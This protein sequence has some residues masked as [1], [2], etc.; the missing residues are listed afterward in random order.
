MKSLQTD[1]AAAAEKLRTSQAENRELATK[2]AAANA[3]VAKL[4]VR[5]KSGFSLVWQLTKGGA[6]CGFCAA[7]SRICIALQATKSATEGL[8]AG[9]AAAA[10]DNG[11]LHAVLRANESLASRAAAAEATASRVPSLTAANAALA[12]RSDSLQA[13]TKR[14]QA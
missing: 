6:A 2:L 14:L 12:A 10:T 5:A 1:G 7:S 9:L 11:Q 8:A 13:D 4:Q 3:D